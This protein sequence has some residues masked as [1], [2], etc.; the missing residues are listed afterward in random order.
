MWT[1]IY[2]LQAMC[3]WC[4]SCVFACI[5]VAQVYYRIV[6]QG[7]LSKYIPYLVCIILFLLFSLCGEIHLMCNSSIHDSHCFSTY[8]NATA[9]RVFLTSFVILY[10]PNIFLTYNICCTV[11]PSIYSRLNVFFY[12]VQTLPLT[13]YDAPLDNPT[14]IPDLCCSFICNSTLICIP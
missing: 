14:Y 13:C 10:S 7:Y 1:N 2:F 6:L 12:I 3:R 4:F 5:T 11:Y 8:N 9:Q